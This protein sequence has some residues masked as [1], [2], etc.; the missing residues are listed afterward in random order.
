MSDALFRKALFLA[1]Q[2]DFVTFGLGLF[3][4]GKVTFLWPGMYH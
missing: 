3:F 4:H 1:R 2:A